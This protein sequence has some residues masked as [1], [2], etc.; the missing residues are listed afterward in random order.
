MPENTF[1][2][3]FGASVAAV[4]AVP[5]NAGSSSPVVLPFAGFC[6]VIFGATVSTVQATRAGLGSRLPDVLTA[7]T[8]KTC[9]ASTSAL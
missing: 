5:E 9:R 7:R 3:T 4:P 2:V 1:T 8:I 6:R